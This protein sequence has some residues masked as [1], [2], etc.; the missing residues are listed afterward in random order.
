MIW[1]RSGFPSTGMARS[2][3]PA[4]R[5]TAEKP[6]IDPVVARSRDRAAHKCGGCPVSRLAV[7]IALPAGQ[8]EILDAMAGE[9]RLSAGQILAREGEARHY[10]FT[11]T[12]G[13]LRR[14]RVLAD[15]RR[16]VAGFLMP[17]DFIGF[18][19]ASHYRHSI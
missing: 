7:C 15:G 10:V 1:A 13:A 11:V 18:S 12:S 4:I 19:G 16:L 5:N 9:V 3:D 14:I 17:G 2:P 8:A 6:A